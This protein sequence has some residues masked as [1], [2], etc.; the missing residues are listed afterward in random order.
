M[1]TIEHAEEAGMVRYTGGAVLFV[2]YDSRG[3]VQNVTTRAIDEADPIQKRDLLG[4]DKRF[5]PVLPGDPT[6]VWIVEGGTDALAMHA[7]AKRRGQLPP[8][9]IVSGGANVRSFLQ[10]PEIQARLRTAE[11]VTIAHEK[12]KDAQTQAQTDAE[13]SKQAQRVAEITGTRCT[14]G[15]RRPSKAR[16]WRSITPASRPLRV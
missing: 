3:L 10:T 7:I 12:E 1:E 4:S 5:P 13:H 6:T 2:G 11:R 16:T 9:V 8:T 15:C 14:T